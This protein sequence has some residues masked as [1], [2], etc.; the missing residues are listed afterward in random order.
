MGEVHVA[1]RFQAL[2]GRVVLRRRRR[3]VDAGVIG[4]H[5]LAELLHLGVLRTR[6]GQL[7]GVDI[8]L[9]GRDHNRC[10][11]WIGDLLCC[12]RRCETHGD[13]KRECFHRLPPHE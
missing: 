13:R 5:Q 7:T 9:I 8:D 4:H 11:L 6:H 10:D 3:L 12:R 2:A 1:A